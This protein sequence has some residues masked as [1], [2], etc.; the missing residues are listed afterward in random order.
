MATYTF[1]TDAVNFEVEATSDNEAASKFAASE[2]I[3]GIATMGGLLGRIAEQGG[4]A[5]VT[6]GRG[7]VVGRVDPN[8]GA[9]EVYP[10]GR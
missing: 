9:V 3:R 2:G 5:T 10:Q 1:A 4:Y 6:D 7:D 8:T